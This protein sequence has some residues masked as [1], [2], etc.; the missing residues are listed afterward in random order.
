M[1]MILYIYIMEKR[2]VEAYSLMRR[3]RMP[4]LWARAAR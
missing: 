2:L 1:L 3:T 4:V